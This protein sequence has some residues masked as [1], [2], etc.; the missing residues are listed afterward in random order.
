[1]LQQQAMQ[2]SYTDVLWLMGVGTMCMLPLLL[3]L[4]KNQPGGKAQMGH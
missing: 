1:M 2:L 4:K 3:L